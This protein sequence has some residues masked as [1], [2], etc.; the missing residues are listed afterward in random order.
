M[1]MYFLSEKP[2]G[3]KIGGA[4]LGLV[5][6]FER[7]AELDLAAAPLCEFLPLQAFQPVRFCL[8]ETFLH[9]PP[10][11][12]RVYYTE[13]GVAVYA[14]GFLRADQS[15][16]VLWQERLGGTLLTLTLQGKLQLDLRD[17]SGF[18]L[19]PLPDGLENCTPSL[20][21]DGYLLTGENCFALVSKRG[22][23]LLFSEGKPLPSEE[24]LKAEVP[25]H[26]CRGHTALMEWREGKLLSC[27]V[28]TPMRPTE[29]TFALAFFESVLIGADPLP[30]LAESLA[31]QAGKL[32]GYLGNFCSV[33]LTES[34]DKVGLLYERRPRVFDVRYFRV[35][36]QDG[37]IGNIKPL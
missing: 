27:T 33:L 9:A 15:L 11:Q 34:P 36:L 24:T 17:G 23:L 13:Q 30:F 6:G 37:K 20:R 22:E 8:D 32:K 29:A 35:E 18:Y 3:L 21:R 5:D 7:F 19:V 4:Y 31:A 28:R 10:E 16:K 12:A 25:F 14:C 2:C 1:R 26:D